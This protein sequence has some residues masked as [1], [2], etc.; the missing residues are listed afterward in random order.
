MTG[1]E[2]IRKGIDAR[3]LANNPELGIRFD[4][5]RLEAGLID[6]P[7]VHDGFEWVYVLEGS[8]EDQNGVHKQGDF[9]ENYQGQKHW[10]KSDDGCK[11]LI[12]WTGSVSKA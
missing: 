9:I 1:W 6:V 5:L 8:F 11:I 7:H 4:I 2:R 12:V 3:K 10:V